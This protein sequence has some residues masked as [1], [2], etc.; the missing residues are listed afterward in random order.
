MKEFRFYS[1]FDEIAQIL[2]LFQETGLSVKY[3]LNDPE[4]GIFPL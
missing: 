3:W 1:G 2:S 4:K